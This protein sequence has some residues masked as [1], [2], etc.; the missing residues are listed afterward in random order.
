M[1]KL[2]IEESATR[3]QVG[4]TKQGNDNIL[5][6]AFDNILSMPPNL[7]LQWVRYL[8]HLRSPPPLHSVNAIQNQIHII[9]TFFIVPSSKGRVLK[10]LVQWRVTIQT[11]DTTAAVTEIDVFCGQRWWSDM[12]LK[13]RTQLLKKCLDHGYG[14][15]TTSAILGFV[16]QS[17]PISCYQ[18]P[19]ELVRQAIE[20]CYCLFTSS[21]PTTTQEKR[22]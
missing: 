14:C 18:T 7:A 22:F 21:L 19:D 9:Y 1:P 13:Y 15:F 2:R 17:N 3:K 4:G 8:I 11:K 16:I 12:R 6:M 20:A 5:S 10:K